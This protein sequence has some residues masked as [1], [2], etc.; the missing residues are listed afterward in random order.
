MS[1]TNPSIDVQRLFGTDLFG[2]REAQRVNEALNDLV[3]DLDRADAPLDDLVAAFRE[4]AE[5]AGVDL[6]EMERRLRDAAEEA[7]EAGEGLIEDIEDALDEAR[8]DDGG[9]ADDG[10]DD[11]DDDNGAAAGGDDN[12]AAAGDDDNGAGQ[13][14][15]DGGNGNGDAGGEG[16]GVAA[17]TVFA[18]VLPAN[19]SG[20]L[21]FAAARLEGRTLEVQFIADNV[22]PG[23]PH[24]LHIHGFPD[25]RAERLAVAADDADGDGFVETAEGAAA[26]FGPIIAS[27]TASGEVDPAL[28][29]SDDFEVADADGR[30]VFT[31]RYKLDPN[32]ADDE[33][34][35]AALQSR[36]EGRVIKLH[37]LDVP[38][39]AG[40]GTPGE[41]NGEGGYAKLLPVAAGQFLSL[42]GVLP[43]AVAARP[44]ALLE[45]L[46][47]LLDSLAPF[48]LKADGSGAIAPDPFAPGDGTNGN[49]AGALPGGAVQAAPEAAVTG[50]PENGTPEN[51]ADGTQDGSE[52]FVAIILPANNSGVFGAARITF[53]EAAGTVAVE[54]DL[55]GLEPG[56]EHA[57]HLHGFAD[58][59][60]SLVPNGTLDADLDGF[61]EAS[62]AAGIIGPVLLGLTTDGGISDATLT[63]D[64]P[65]ADA[66]GIAR[67]RQ[68]YAFDLDD[69]AEAALFAE[70]QDR[71]EGRQLQVH[72]L[73]L[74]AAQGEGTRG[75]VSG[76]AG[77]Q[78]LVAV[79]H[80]AVLAT[81]DAGGQFAATLAAL[82]QET[83][84]AQTAEDAPTAA[85]PEETLIA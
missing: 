36:L 83:I 52:T 8:E 45:G 49:G 84:V 7:G 68:D 56:Q 61:V 44:E 73:T 14:G 2:D 48:T 51:G 6:A 32:E 37:G 62:E 77:F 19:N 4:A 39:G 5:E 76:E 25:D 22:T 21:G 78:P 50:A 42:A 64:F 54:M 13:D 34:V 3:R 9:S 85:R 74:D 60:A 70:L 75:E 28:G 16:G 66:N 40:E 46:T 63:G 20:A 47:A 18:L 65:V 58:D 43:E 29:A 27:L 67:L 30:I 72:G 11:G 71:M 23:Q 1:G 24:P 17:Q 41:V 10:A 80:G 81:D 38:E 12:G 35:L 59:R 82:L 53:D 69:P 26:A 55:A 15:D 79:A 57:A 31:R 33:D